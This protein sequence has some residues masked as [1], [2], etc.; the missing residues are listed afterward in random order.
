MD[1]S[2]NPSFAPRRNSFVWLAALL[3][4]FAIFLAALQLPAPT[5]DVPKSSLLGWLS[6]LTSLI[7]GYFLT[8]ALHELGHAAAGALTRFKLVVLL[9]GPFKAIRHEGGLRIH[10]DWKRPFQFRGS[11]LTVPVDS[12][13][14]HRPK[15]WQPSWLTQ[16]LTPDDAADDALAAN[17][18]AY[19][20]ALDKEDVSQAAAYLGKLHD[21]LQARPLQQWE[22]AYLAETAYF[23]ARYGGRTAVARDWFNRARRLQ[24]RILSPELEMIFLRAETAVLLAEGRQTE[25]QIITERGQARAARLLRKNGCKPSWPQLHCQK[26]SHILSHS[27]LQTTANDCPS[28]PCSVTW[29]P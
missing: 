17:F 7:L 5:Y 2:T 4:Y 18:M 12:H 25:A 15:D 21:I 24:A 6:A 1:S 3:G 19:V 27:C 28:R 11:T 20:H 23:E 26:K 13:S 8:L 22:P 10:F 29:R 14:L 9:V 16:A